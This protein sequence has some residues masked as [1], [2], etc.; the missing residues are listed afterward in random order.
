MA[1]RKF[2][3]WEFFVIVPAKSERVRNEKDIC[4]K[5]S[6]REAPKGTKN[7]KVA[8]TTTVILIRN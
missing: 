6:P 5:C 4:I 1:E 3:M 7:R 2:E 8:W